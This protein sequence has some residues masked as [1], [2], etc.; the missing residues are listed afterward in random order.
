M[1]AFTQ[2]C[3]T[4]SSIRSHKK[5]PPDYYIRGHLKVNSFVLK[6]SV[7][8]IRRNFTW[9]KDSLKLKANV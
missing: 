9:Q 6:Y 7:A 1:A 2:S 5:F 3:I 4:A 8:K